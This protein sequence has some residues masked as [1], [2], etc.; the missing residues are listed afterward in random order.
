MHYLEELPSWLYQ[1]I[2]TVYLLLYLYG[3]THLQATSLQK[4][5]QKYPIFFVK[6]I[7]KCFKQLMGTAKNDI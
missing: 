5:V 2:I 4:Q 7:Q 1:G 3:S 6:Y